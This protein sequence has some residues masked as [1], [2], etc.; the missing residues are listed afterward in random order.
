MKNLVVCKLEGQNIYNVLNAI[1]KQNIKIYNI[2]K[3]ANCIYKI[4]ILYKKYEKV[5][6]ICREYSI[7]CT[8]LQEVGTKSFLRKLLFRVGIL[9]GVCFAISFIWFCS[10]FVW[11]VNIQLTGA[12]ANS[13]AEKLLYEYLDNKGISIGKRLN[14]L[15]VSSLERDLVVNFSNISNIVVTKK[16]VNIYVFGEINKQND[17]NLKSAICADRDG[18]VEEI[19]LNAGKIVVRIG[20]I[21]RKGDVII[22]P[23]DNGVCSADVYIKTWITAEDVGFV[24][25]ESLRRTGRVQ[26][27]NM[28]KWPFTNGNQSQTECEFEYYET[29]V[30]SH[31]ICNNLFIPISTICTTY[32]E[33]EKVTSIKTLSDL[34]MGM[35][36][37]LSAQI[38]NELPDSLYASEV[39]FNI[40]EN[41]DRVRVV[42]SREIVYK[43]A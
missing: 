15:D 26:V 30:E 3:N 34:T 38:E 17:K 25:T 19:K 6:Q 2:V 35:K 40:Y 23:D 21:V 5:L 8:I 22:E 39:K 36:Q 18:I 29:D 13:D 41:E 37:Q 28:I 31:F 42:A 16:G 43:L 7:N 27:T 33:L 11:N 20:N 14:S 10:G 12:Q 9:I 4:T 32:H 1:K 24:E